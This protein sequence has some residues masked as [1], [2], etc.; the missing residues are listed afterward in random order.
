MRF[1]D[2]QSI[3]EAMI[4]AEGETVELKTPVDVNIPGNKGVAECWLDELK[5]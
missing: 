3:I 2:N 4:F 5:F 1:D